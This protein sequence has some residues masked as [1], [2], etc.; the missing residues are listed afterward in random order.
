MRKLFFLIKKFIWLFLYEID[1]FQSVKI[2]YDELKIENSGYNI[3]K[4]LYQKV[5]DKIN[6]I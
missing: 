2:D 3:I 1:C 5:I 6:G 4:S